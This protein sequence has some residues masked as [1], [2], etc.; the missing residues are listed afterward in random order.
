M[1]KRMAEPIRIVIPWDVQRTSH[2]AHLHWRER[3]RR[4]AAAKQ[5]AHLA[6]L[7]AGCPQVQGP[8]RVS[9]VARRGRAMDLP[10]IVDGAKPCIDGLLTGGRVVPDDSPAWLREVH[11]M[12]QETGKQWKGREELEVV[13]EPLEVPE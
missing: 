7:K 2:N 8:V 4:T 13:I 11:C 1:S 10:N 6:W 5:A 3:H 9:L 12:E